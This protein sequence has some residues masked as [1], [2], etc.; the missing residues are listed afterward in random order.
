MPKC[1]SSLVRAW[2]SHIVHRISNKSQINMRLNIKIQQW[3]SIYVLCDVLVVE[4][5]LSSSSLLLVFLFL[6]HL[7]LHSHST[8][9]NYQSLVAFYVSTTIY[10]WLYKRFTMLN[11]HAAK[12]ILLKT[13]I[14]S[15]STSELFRKFSFLLS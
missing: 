9:M 5:M 2:A 12:I 3:Y 6:L 4:K 11:T 14:I 15:K 13:W 8:Y 10:L 7:L 1:D